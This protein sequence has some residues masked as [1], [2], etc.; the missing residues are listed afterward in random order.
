MF[1]SEVS[2]IKLPICILKPPIRLSSILKS[3]FI[4]DPI[5]LDNSLLI[6][7]SSSEVKFFDEINCA[8]NLPLLIDT[9]SLKLKIIFL[10]FLENSLF[11]KFFLQL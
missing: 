9:K 3:K 1:L 7:V 4:F 10:K 5:T 11:Q 6:F 2:T 8:F